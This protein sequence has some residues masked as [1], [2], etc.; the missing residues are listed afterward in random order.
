MTLVEYTEAKNL[1]AKY[2]IKSVESAY[3]S[4]AGSAVKFSKGK[5]IVLKGIS[6]K[7]LHKTKAGLVRV[8]LATPK[9]IESAFSDISKAARQ[10][11]PY[12]IQA[13]VMAG[14]GVEII[15]GGVTDP[16]FGKLIL[17][18]LGGIYVE[19]FKDFALRTCPITR[20]DAESMI[21]QL[22]SKEVITFNGENRDMVVD[23]LLRTS[24][25]ILQNKSINQLDLNPIILRKDS[26][27]VVD[28]RMMK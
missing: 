10:F 19:A 13:Q 4:T 21:D 17:L 23:L 3:V 22:K 11:A 27:D 20:Y 14:S 25:L 28:I 5:R 9:E 7:A 8:D 26:Y 18:G 16:Q 15:M 24:R 2:G 6:D 1:L 12:R